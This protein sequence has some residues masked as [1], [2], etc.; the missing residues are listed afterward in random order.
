M[1]PISNSTVN[2][3]SGFNHWNSPVP[4]L[5][6]GLGLMLGLIAVSLV[7]LAC[8]YKIETPNSYREEDEGEGENPTKKKEDLKP[9]DMEPKIVV[10]MAGDEN[11]TFFAKPLKFDAFKEQS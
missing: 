4:Y 5:F 11:P 2:I 3:E 1:R 10:V 8:S 7:I 9:L 6:C